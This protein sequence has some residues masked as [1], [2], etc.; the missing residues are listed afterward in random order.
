M[1]L[2]PVFLNLTK[3]NCLIIGGGIVAERK[4]LDL[5]EAQANITV[6]SPEV[7]SILETKSRDCEIKLLRRRYIP[8]DLSGF[9]LIIAATNDRAVNEEIFTEA[10]KNQQ[11]LNSVDDPPSCNFYVPA[12]VRRGF[13]Q[14]AISTSGK[15]PMLARELR[16]YIEKVIYP[17]IEKKFLPLSCVRSNIINKYKNHPDQITAQK[18]K[19]EEL[20]DTLKPMIENI[21]AGKDV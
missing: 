12:R 8:G 10:N 13:I 4:V 9:H 15:I 20:N 11:W 17:G 5:L 1:N 16:K 18:K 2:Y 21:L 14:I 6:I 7:T 3:K 19:N